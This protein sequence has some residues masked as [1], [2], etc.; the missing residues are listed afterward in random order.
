MLYS[1]D[2]LDL[3]AKYKKEKFNEKDSGY[4][5]TKRKEKTIPT[6]VWIAV[7]IFMSYFVIT[8]AM[9]RLEKYKLDKKREVAE[10]LNRT[11]PKNTQHPIEQNI[12]TAKPKEQSVQS[13]Q[14][15][16]PIIMTPQ[17]VQKQEPITKAEHSVQER[18]VK[19]NISIEVR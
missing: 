12:I 11:I 4:F 16:K 19:P 10:Q 2:T 13:I 15:D 9:D 7:I 14:H 6:F 17:A 3:V 18:V 8:N 1:D 5:I